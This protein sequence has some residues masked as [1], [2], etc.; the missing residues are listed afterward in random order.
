MSIAP[1]S[2]NLAHLLTSGLDSL[3]LSLSSPVRL[4]AQRKKR[5]NVQG[6]FGPVYCTGWLLSSSFLEGI[7]QRKDVKMSPVG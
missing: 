1:G 5:D 6:F 7:R 3:K 4:S 2:P